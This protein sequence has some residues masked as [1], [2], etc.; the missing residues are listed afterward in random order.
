[1][2]LELEE[3]DSLLVW[4]KIMVTDELSW[5]EAVTTAMSVIEKDFHEFQPCLLEISIDVEV[6]Q[7]MLLPDSTHR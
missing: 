3:M 7:F 4:R 6:G 1:M 5:N 2:V